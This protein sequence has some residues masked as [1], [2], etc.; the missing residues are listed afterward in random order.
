VFL[1]S[2]A[3]AWLV[4]AAAPGQLDPD[5]YFHF[6]V[7]RQLADGKLW[8]DIGWLPFT[9]LGEA[10]PDHHWLWHL[11]LAP[12][13]LAGEPDFALQVTG[14]VA[15]A[16][17]PAVLTAILQVLG[18]RYAGLWA[19]LAVFSASV[20][21]GRL[22]MLRAQNLA[23]LL[24]LASLL[25]LHS[26]RLLALGLLGFIFMAAYHGAVVLAPLG[27]IYLAQ[28]WWFD[29]RVD[30]T[31]VLALGGGATLA[32]LL[33]PWPGQ[34][35]E[36]LLFHTLYKTSLTL[37][38]TAGT[39]WLQLPFSALVTQ[40]WMAH[41]LLLLATGL[42]VYR[43]RKEPASQRLPALLLIS[44][45]LFLA[46]FANSWRFLEYYAPLAV[47]A[48]AVVLSGFAQLQRYVP[49]VLA[50]LL[51]GGAWQA[52]Q[53]ISRAERYDTADFAEIR[54]YLEEHA[55]AGEIVLNSHWP[56]FPLLLW[57]E[58]RQRYVAGLDA[59][60]L[61]FEDPKRFLL[62]WQLAAAELELEGDIS[63]VIAESFDTRWVVVNRGN[64]LL[65]DRLRASPGAIL[66]AASARAEL[67]L[68][69]P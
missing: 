22:L 52:G 60:Y 2:G 45:L 18:V 21:P 59:S 28:R 38:G 5:T 69:K 20:L 40:A 44:V 53:A 35:I 42:F 58:G 1:G 50:V 4:M 17:V 49:W 65:A 46:L 33:T 67:F 8:L 55:D 37:P 68:L 39:E 48:A 27:L 32:L 16:A 24:V 13:T 11:L 7:S 3:W 6:L 14:A 29:R 43:Y 34:N 57:P 26:R 41:L 31:P 64:A 62:W 9:V 12:L 25:C 30:L 23:L 51:V 54:D 47:V 10:G 36:Y 19:L 56:D 66:V 15:F 61:A 63:S